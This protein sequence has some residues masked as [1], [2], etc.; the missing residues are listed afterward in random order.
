MAQQ[1]SLDDSPGIT[2]LARQLGSD[3]KH[4][5]AE[6]ARLAKLE[7]SVSVRRAG[8]GAMWLG[9]AFGTATVAIVALTILL[10][11]AIGGAANGHYWVGA[12][13]TAGIELVVGWRLVK[14]GLS[15]FKRAPYSLAQTRSGI[16][17]LKNIGHD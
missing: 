12:F 17:L 2:D 5:I 7:L 11:A 14:R 10:I 8:H 16:Q 1:I 4:L 13:V 6:E 9:A 15:D 3:G